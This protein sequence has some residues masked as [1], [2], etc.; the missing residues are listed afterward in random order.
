MQALKEMVHTQMV[1][2]VQQILIAY[3]ILVQSRLVTLLSVLLLVL[4]KQREN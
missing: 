4:L 1:V 3:P 2:N